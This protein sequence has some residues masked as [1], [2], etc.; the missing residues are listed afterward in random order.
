MAKSKA[1]PKQT[2]RLSTPSLTS[3]MGRKPLIRQG[4]PRPAN[5]SSAFR[6][7]FPRG[8]VGSS[9]IIRTIGTDS[10]GSRR[11]E[12]VAGRSGSYSAC[13]HLLLVAVIVILVMGLVPF[14]VVVDL[15]MIA[16]PVTLM[17]ELSIM[18]RL[19]PV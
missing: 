9:P 16:I 5:P 11:L 2:C 15:A 10:D 8:S 18:G 3:P 1:N 6:F 12:P 14:M 13:A 17:V 7:Q 19:H 4:A